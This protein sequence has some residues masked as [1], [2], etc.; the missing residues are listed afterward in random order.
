MAKCEGASVDP[1]EAQLACR[2]D[3][4][5]ILATRGVA[6]N[7]REEAVHLVPDGCSA[8]QAGAIQEEPWHAGEQQGPLCVSQ[9]LIR[10]SGGL[11][12]PSSEPSPPIP[13]TES[14]SWLAVGKTGPRLGFPLA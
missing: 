12:L 13:H 3:A 4:P 8:S 6:A 1:R 9:A 7:L 11:G 5:S 10:A 2:L 14:L